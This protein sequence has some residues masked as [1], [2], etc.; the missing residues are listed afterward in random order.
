M[1]SLPSACI[2]TFVSG[3]GIHWAEE[4][5]IPLIYICLV[6]TTLSHVLWNKVLAKRGAS[7]CASFYP[8]QPLTSM[9]L[10][11]VFLSE[12]LSFQL[13]AGAF[14]IVLAMIVRQKNTGHKIKFIRSANPA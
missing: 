11:I 7:F 13:A 3:E 10:G 12:K 6:C 9:L 14:C 4:M 1:L 2:Y 5:I 8:L